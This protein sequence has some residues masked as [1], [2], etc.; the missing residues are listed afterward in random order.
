[1][2]ISEVFKRT[3]EAAPS[4]DD[5]PGYSTAVDTDKP[6]ENRTKFPIDPIEMGNPSGCTCDE[7]FGS[8][9]PEETLT[10][11]RTSP[12]FS[13]ERA[14]PYHK[15][16]LEG[17]RGMMRSGD[18]DQI[19]AFTNDNG[20]ADSRRMSF[21]THL[22][23]HVSKAGMHPRELGVSDD[24]FENYKAQK[25]AMD[26]KDESS[27]DLPTGGSN[28]CGTCGQ[29]VKNFKDAVV[30][31]K[32]R[33]MNDKLK[34]GPWSTEHAKKDA[35]SVASSAIDSWKNGESTGGDADLSNI[36]TILGDFDKHSKKE[37]GVSYA[38]VDSSHIPIAAPDYSLEA[39]STFDE[40]ARSPKKEK[41]F[42][43]LLNLSQ[44]WDVKPT[45]SAV[46]KDPFW[47]KEGDRPAVDKFPR[48]TD[49]HFNQREQDYVNDL[50]DGKVE[51]HEDY[52][53]EHIKR[54][55]ESVGQWSE[56][57]KKIVP[58]D[59]F[60]PKT[61]IDLPWHTI[62][63]FEQRFDGDS[64]YFTRDRTYTDS[65]STYDP[66][67]DPRPLKVRSAEDIEGHPEITVGAFHTG[68]ESEIP[69]RDKFLFQ[70]AAMM[71]NL[72]LVKEHRKAMQAYENQPTHE[73]VIER[74]D[75][76]PGAPLTKK[77]VR[78]GVPIDRSPLTKVVREEVP[79]L[80]ENGNQRFAPDRQVPVYKQ[81]T[82]SVPKY[83]YRKK[84]ETVTKQ[85]PETDERGTAL[86]H[87]D[88]RPKLR[89]Q[90]LTQEVN[91]IEGGLHPVLDE[92]GNHVHE[93]VTRPMLQIIPEERRIQKPEL[94]VM[95]AR[96]AYDDSRREALS[97]V[98][99]ADDHVAEDTLAADHANAINDKTKEIITSPKNKIFI[100]KKEEEMPKF[101]FNSSKKEAVHPGI[102]VDVGQA[103]HGLKDV[104][105]MLMTPINQ[106]KELVSPSHNISDIERHQDAAVQLMGEGV[107][108]GRLLEK[109]VDKY[110]KAVGLRPSVK[111]KFDKAFRVLHP[112]KA[113]DDD[114]KNPVT[115]SVIRELSARISAAK[116]PCT[117]CGKKCAD[118]DECKANQEQA[119]R[120]RAA[121]NAY[122]D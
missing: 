55:V 42:D 4:I 89:F 38:D 17:I 90:T 13:P 94:D 113:M 58:G 80:D 25:Y 31:Y 83:D 68:V 93:T 72:D 119:K 37:H 10:E 43:K 108:A 66:S 117:D 21:L 2:K 14:Q 69:R 98:Y 8:S 88:G 110:D 52:A 44:G 116:K 63:G 85:M 118:K 32:N 39:E 6:K 29:Y 36:H 105:H 41:I 122:N 62:Q 18:A 28:S 87:P 73:P 109:G 97:R 76:V 60:R 112:I 70:Q 106:V 27:E 3:K 64:H 99:G 54:N 16:I 11:M 50:I 71:P 78:E 77:V 30:N 92:Q 67:K 102:L 15:H 79:D 26:H 22:F 74:Y 45:E 121:E 75:T 103:L 24:Q 33:L 104:G 82:V 49:Q 100:S 95:G 47:N 91:D 5:A 111:D 84:T 20:D 35:A 81:E 34:T 96:K 23:H 65:G 107:G 101:I 9:I 115:S 12:N 19:D 51:G 59:S 56:R 48:E 61:T 120:D 53:K 114:E 40:P 46:G 86:F 57:T 7:L 1:M